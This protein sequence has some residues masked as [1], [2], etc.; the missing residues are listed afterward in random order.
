MNYL[1]LKNFVKSIDA[2]DRGEKIETGFEVF[3]P[4][5]SVIKMKIAQF[6]SDHYATWSI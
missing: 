3:M 5:N 2:K 1:V 4:L 6:L